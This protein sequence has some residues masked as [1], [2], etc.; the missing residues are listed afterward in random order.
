MALSSL[1]P[2]TYTQW[3]TLNITPFPIAPGQSTVGSPDNRVG[4]TLAGW[5][6]TNLIAFTMT[7]QAMINTNLNI[8][9][10][11]VNTLDATINPGSNP[12]SQTTYWTIDMGQ[13]A[14]GGNWQL[15]FQVDD[16]NT[17]TG[18]WVFTKGKG[19]DDFPKY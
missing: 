8:D 4:F 19:D 7:Q 5:V 11:T 12:T 1:T 17:D 3:R 14:S 2:L 10:I 18:K 16:G 9:T 13:N 6:G 15:S